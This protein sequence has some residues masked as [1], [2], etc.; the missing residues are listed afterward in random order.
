MKT[1]FRAIVLSFGVLLGACGIQ[2]PSENFE[3][4]DGSV[5]PRGTWA[6]PFRVN[7]SGRCEI[8][9]KLTQII[10]DSDAILGLG[11]GLE[12]GGN[13]SLLHEIQASTNRNSLFD[14][15]REGNYC[16]IVRDVGFLSRG[17][18]FTVRVQHP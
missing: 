9:L 6:H 12:N 14:E 5:L 17:Q 13:C 11:L 3:N 10:P 16:V 15:V 18:N 4:F 7:C 1:G 2:T 8:T